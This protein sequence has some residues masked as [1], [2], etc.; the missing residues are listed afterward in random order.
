MPRRANVGAPTVQI[1]RSERDRMTAQSPGGA[2][3]ESV[4]AFLR[5]HPP[6]D[7]MEEAPLA[8]L[9]A[10]SRVA[11]FAQG[12]SIV[13]PG[14]GVAGTF[15]VVNRG[16]VLIEQSTG[17][18]SIGASNLVVGPGECFPLSAVV[19]TRATTST[20]RAAGDVFCYAVPGDRFRE[21]MRASPVLLEFCTRHLTMLL[22]RSQGLLHDRAGQ[23]SLEEQGMT[24]PLATL[25]RRDPVSCAADTAIGAV[26]ERMRDEHIGSMVIADTAGAPL[27]IFTER[28]ALVRVAAARFDPRA[29]IAQVMT[30]SPLALALTATAGE[31]GL[32]MA[33]HGIRHVVVVDGGKFRGIVSER[34][35]FSLQR[36]SLRR[37]SANI[38]TA[39]SVPDVRRA[40]TD[41]RRLTRNLL[42]QGITAE[43]LT[44]FIAE[45]N[46]RLTRRII[47]ITLVAPCA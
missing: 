36:V 23:Y 3:A 44:Q 34:D 45:L 19:G 2:I 5:R 10:A 37:I 24:A 18:L 42:A 12:E 1:A 9:A 40:A 30:P 14:D 29:E 22:S 25:L 11:Y 39:A 15:Y 47:E 17:N 20:Y 38:A 26:L 32:L 4:I 31:A 6:F 46:D 27:G 35:L 33:R 8:A 16:R 28:D 43:P 21:I 7:H 13:A 41:I